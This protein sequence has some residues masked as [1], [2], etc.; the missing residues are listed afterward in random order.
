MVEAGVKNDWTKIFL[1]KFLSDPMGGEKKVEK[2][3]EKKMEESSR[4]GEVGETKLRR[5]RRFGEITKGWNLCS[6]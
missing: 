6:L 2:K 1:E 4:S 3:M 5:K